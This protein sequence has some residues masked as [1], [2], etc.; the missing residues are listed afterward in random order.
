MKRL[1]AWLFSDPPNWPL[2]FLWLVFFL[3]FVGFVVFAILHPNRETEPC[4]AGYSATY[5]KSGQR[6]C[7]RDCPCT[8]PHF[9][10]R[11]DTTP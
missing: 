11:K 2:A 1:W 4:P 5:T 9:D 10:E 8:D 7:K 3:Y 6:F